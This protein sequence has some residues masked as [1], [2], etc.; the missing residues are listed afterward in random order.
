MRCSPPAV[1]S[2]RPPAPSG[3][4]A[5]IRRDRLGV[6]SA[7]RS[8]QLPTTAGFWREFAHGDSIQAVANPN[9]A[10]LDNP[11]IN[12]LIDRSLTAGPDQWAAI[13]RQAEELETI[14]YVYIVD[15]HDHLRGLVSA[16][17]L[18][19]AIGKPMMFTRETVDDAGF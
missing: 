6:A 14:Y 5:T 8:S 18:L 17:Q 3:P 1:S 16:R 2:A 7:G 19:S 10:A 4:P 11:A 12:R 13:G 9:I 15:E